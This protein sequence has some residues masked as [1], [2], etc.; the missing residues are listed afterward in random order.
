M[1]IKKVHIHQS[2]LYLNKYKHFHSKKD[3][4]V[5]LQDIIRK[6]LNNKK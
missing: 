6:L 1:Y 5:I 4:K 2:A 3:T